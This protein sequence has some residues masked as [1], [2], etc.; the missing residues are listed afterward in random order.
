MFGYRRAYIAWRRA[1]ES[2]ERA[3]RE[4]E[5]ILNK[6]EREN[7]RLRNRVVEL[8]REQKRLIQYALD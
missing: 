4:A 3:F 7:E 2:W 1:A 5:A 8:E 6:Y